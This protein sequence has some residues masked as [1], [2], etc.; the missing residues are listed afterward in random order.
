MK[1]RS[2]VMLQLNSFMHNGLVVSA[3]FANGDESIY[4]SGTSVA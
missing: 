4:R 3:R 1:K 2:E